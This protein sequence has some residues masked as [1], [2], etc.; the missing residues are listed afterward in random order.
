MPS[1]IVCSSSCHYFLKWFSIRPES[2]KS[3]ITAKWMRSLQ[4][5][6]LLMNRKEIQSGDR[7]EFTGVFGG[8]RS[9]SKLYLGKP[10]AAQSHQQRGTTG[11]HGKIRHQSKVAGADE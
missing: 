7:E 8:R 4:S 6:T 9:G 10:V 5:A 11:Q 2:G 3:V 1:D